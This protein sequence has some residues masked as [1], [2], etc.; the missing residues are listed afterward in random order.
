MHR[1]LTAC[2]RY[3]NANEK[4]ATYT[5]DVLDASFPTEQRLADRTTLTIT[6]RN[7]DSK[8]VPDVAV[9]V[10][11]AEASAPAAAFAEANSQPGLAD[12]SRPVWVLDDGPRG[13]DFYNQPEGELL[14][15]TDWVA[16]V[17][18]R[19][20]PTA[21]VEAGVKAAAAAHLANRSLRAGK[22]VSWDDVK[23]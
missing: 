8:R 3:R 20:T 19:K 11:G 7:A 23:P 1:R 2:S 14:H 15:L 9:T 21:P 22:I 10:L 16:A 4:S 17:R 18:S 6:V 12:P 5:L 13:L